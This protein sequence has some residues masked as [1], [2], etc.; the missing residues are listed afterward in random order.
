MVVGKRRRPP[1]LFSRFPFLLVVQLLLLLLH[2]PSP[3]YDVFALTITTFNILAPVHRSMT[4]QNHRESEREDWWRPRALGVADYISKRLD[5]SDVVLLQEWWF[6]YE[7]ASIFDHAMGDHFVRVAERRPGPG[8]HDGMCCLIRKT[9]RLE[10]VKSK[11]V[12]TGPQRIAQIVHCRERRL[13]NYDHDHMHHPPR[14]VYIANA[15]LSYPGDADPTVNEMRQANEATIILDALTNARYEWVDGIEG[16]GKEDDDAHVVATATTTESKLNANS[17]TIHTNEYS[18]LEGI[19]GDFNSDST[20]LAASIVE[21]RGF[22]NCASAHAEQVLT[23]GVGGRVNVGVT[24][25]DHLGKK[26][27]VDHVFLRSVV[28]GGGGASIGDGRRTRD[29]NNNHRCAALALGFL[30]ERGTRVLGVRRGNIHLEGS[31]VLSDHRPVTARIVWPTASEMDGKRTRRR[32]VLNS[33]V[34]V[35]ATMPL[36]PL[37]PAWGIIDEY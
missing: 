30:D 13:S 10:F 4:D 3:E 14:D 28:R 22:A 35:N 8:R 25:M 31:A 2:H 15:H 9:G 36:D 5:T 17:T 6:D 29:D 27:S 21:S 7:F 16:K 33:D 12:I 11:V 20:G 23:G 26:V 18:W 1:P 37:E 32:E 19:C 34:Y 24:H